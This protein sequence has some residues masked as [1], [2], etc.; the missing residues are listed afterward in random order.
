MGFLANARIERCKSFLHHQSDFSF[1][2]K[3]LENPM[4]FCI[5]QLGLAKIPTSQMECCLRREMNFTDPALQLTASFPLKINGWKITCPF[6]ALAWPIFRGKL[7]VSFREC[8]VVIKIEVNTWVA[9][10]FGVLASAI[11]G[12]ERRRSFFFWAPKIW[13]EKPTGAFI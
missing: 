10:C 1:L 13:G 8:K 9:S 4:W 5:I 3:T 7:A 11:S 6:G 12:A 2:F